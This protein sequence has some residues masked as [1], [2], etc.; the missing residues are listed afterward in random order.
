MRRLAFAWLA[1]APLLLL[2]LIWLPVW[3]HYRVPGLAAD[4]AMIDSLR[5][6]GTRGIVRPE[7]IQ[8]LLDTHL[9]AHPGYYGEMVWILMMLEQWL[10]AKAPRFGLVTAMTGDT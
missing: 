1:V 9:P 4:R 6:L 2:L 8:Q 5:A 3:Q 7:F 10:A